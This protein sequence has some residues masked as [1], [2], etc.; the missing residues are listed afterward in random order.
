MPDLTER[1][2]GI[3][4]HALCSWFP[5]LSTNP[6]QKPAPSR[7]PL[8]STS[9]W[10]SCPNPTVCP[11]Y[12]TA[13]CSLLQ[14]SRGMCWMHPLSRAPMHTTP[15]ILSFSSW[16]SRLLTRAVK[17]Q[18]IFFLFFSLQ[19]WPRP[20]V[21]SRKSSGKWAPPKGLSSALS[22]KGRRD[23]QGF[24]HA[25]ASR[26][27]PPPGESVGYSAKSRSSQLMPFASIAA[28]CAADSASFCIYHLLFYCFQGH[29]CSYFVWQPWHY[30]GLNA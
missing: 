21:P 30:R 6:A 15:P 13:R 27:S 29:S 23:S 18:E 26:C 19:G 4:N 11:P 10:P 7:F 24:R 1:L 28:R 16:G 2:G 22:Q 14:P 8:H 12:P 17:N 3:R 5:M 20:A 25:W 9:S